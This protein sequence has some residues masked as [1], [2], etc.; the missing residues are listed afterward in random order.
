M[1][2]FQKQLQFNL[3]S[4]DIGLY[5][6]PQFHVRQFQVRHFQSTQNWLSQCAICFQCTHLWE[7][8]PC[9]AVAWTAD[10]RL[11]FTWT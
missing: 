4:N 1:L 11:E 9:L 7:L 5:F 2:F 10:D 8:G 3:V 6:V